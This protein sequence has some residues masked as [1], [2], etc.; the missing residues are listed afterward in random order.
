MRHLGGRLVVKRTC[1]LKIKERA[2]NGSRRKKPFLT[3]LS[4]C[5]NTVTLF[6]P[7]S[8]GDLLHRRRIAVLVPVVPDKAQ[9]LQLPRRNDQARGL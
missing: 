7:S 6:T 4:T 1:S 5:S 3:R 9:D 2:L 8:D